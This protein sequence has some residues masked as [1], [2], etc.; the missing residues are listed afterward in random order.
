MKLKVLPLSALTLLA[1]ASMSYGDIV[2]G[3]G[4]LT[5]SDPTFVNPGGAT[6]G[7]ARHYYDVFQLTVSATGTYVF[8]LSS[9][10]TSTTTSNALDTF[11]RI[12]ANTFN[13]AA[14]GAGQA[15]NDD[16][17]G[18]LTV[19]P[20]P[21]A[22]MGLTSSATGFQGAQPSSRLGTVSLTA[23]TTYFMVVTSFRETNFVNT[24]TTAGATGNYFYGISGP[25]VIT[26]VPEPGSVAL[27]S[28]GALALGYGAWRKRK[29][30]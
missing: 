21:F 28:L 11:L 15:S 13:P 2:F 10:N 20:G 1:A 25:G 7:T 24:G 5:T 14:P 6:T 18:T 27:L 23:G 9:R 30:A 8:E 22:S 17:T 19:L 29:S 26:V 3:S 12:Y 4:A 16:F